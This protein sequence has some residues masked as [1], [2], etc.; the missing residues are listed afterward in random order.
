MFFIKKSN[1]TEEIT[2]TQNREEALI[3]LR[4]LIRANRASKDWMLRNTNYS[5][6]AQGGIYFLFGKQHDLISVILAA[7]LIFIIW[8]VSIWILT[9]NRES[10]KRLREKEADIIDDVPLPMIK[11]HWAGKQQRKNTDNRYFNIYRAF[12]IGTGLL[13]LIN[14]GR[15]SQ[16]TRNAFCHILCNPATTLPKVVKDPAQ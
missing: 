3:Y 4:E 7:L 2:N 16:E 11:K 13:L 1:K 8:G 6:L 9:T 12:I 14:L 15:N 5:V 10:I